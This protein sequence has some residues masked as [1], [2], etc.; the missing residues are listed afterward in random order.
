MPYHGAVRHITFPSPR[1]RHAHREPY[2]AVRKKL[3]S[4]L[5]S[6]APY[7]AALPVA[8]TTFYEYSCV[9]GSDHAAQSYYGTLSTKETNEIESSTFNKVEQ[10]VHYAFGGRRFEDVAHALF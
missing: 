8:A 9:F 7:S 5:S 6:S 1:L 10:A 2:I 4:S 3:S